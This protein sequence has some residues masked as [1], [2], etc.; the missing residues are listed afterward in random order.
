MWYAVLEEKMDRMILGNQQRQVFLVWNKIGAMLFY[1][2][3]PVLQVI[4]GQVN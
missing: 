4:N 2:Q 1:L 3:T